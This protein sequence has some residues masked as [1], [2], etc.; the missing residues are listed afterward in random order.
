M[1][2]GRGVWSCGPSGWIRDTA[3]E[4]EREGG[5]PLEALGR[6]LSLRGPA[7]TVIV[8]EPRGMSHT[9]I[10]TPRVSRTVFSSL[11]RVRG[12]H[13][14]VCSD[15]LGWGI[16]PPEPVASGTYM[17]LLHCEMAP[18]LRGLCEIAA[19]S[20]NS[21]QAAW[22]VYTAAE[23]LVRTKAEPRPSA[24]LF[25][26]P[27]FVAVASLVPGR[28]TFRA[29]TEP[30]QERDWNSLLGVL[31]VTGRP[32]PD[33]GIAEGSRA[34][35]I[36]VVAE[37]KPG[38]LCPQWKRIEETGRVGT[39][40]GLADLAERASWLAASHPAN[41]REVFPQRFSLDRQLV[42]AMAA[43]VIGT[44]VLAGWTVKARNRSHAELVGVESRIG[45]LEHQLVHLEN[46]R[47]AMV[48]MQTGLGGLG[49][50]AVGDLAAA[51]RR[52]AAAVPDSV[53]L[54][55]LNVGPDRA[56][57]IEADTDPSDFRP[58]EVRHLLSSAGFVPRD[59]EGWCYRAAD[60]KL[61]VNGVITKD[62]P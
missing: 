51:L 9:P 43:G 42:G 52:L 48:A 50:G 45:E 22:P 40:Y 62:S 16:E 8:F 4:Q 18:G 15:G 58:E 37:Q 7:R 47:A 30:M 3:E 1:L 41:L 56:F 33:Q 36:A 34:G 35:G 17:T 12:E 2:L 61:T 23:A 55:S 31:E 54:E 39:V 26:V 24:F 20:G 49:T 59:P 11:A 5:S 25:L 27:G 46:N 6:L 53:T 57:Q 44:A 10:E 14:A 21:V 13:P 29:W 19:R 32:A 28:R 60:N 38:S